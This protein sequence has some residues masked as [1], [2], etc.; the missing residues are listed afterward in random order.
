[1]VSKS[2]HSEGSAGKWCRKADESKREVTEKD[3]D[4]NNNKKVRGDEK[5]PSNIVECMQGCV[6]E[7]VYACEN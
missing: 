7:E 1:M 6:R 2:K 3:N 5:V 4:E